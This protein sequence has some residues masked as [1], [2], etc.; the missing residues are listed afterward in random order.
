MNKCRRY[1]KVD[2]QNENY[3]H[4]NIKEHNCYRVLTKKSRFFFSS[5][6]G[7]TPI[8]NIT[9][10]LILPVYFCLCQGSHISSLYLINDLNTDVLIAT[11]P[12]PIMLPQA[13]IFPLHLLFVV[14][15][16]FLNVVCDFPMYCTLHF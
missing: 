14:A 6:V 7:V 8:L 13:P 16:S 5:A 11:T 12:P 15:V 10:E 4:K 2:Y 1:Y 3:L 9:S